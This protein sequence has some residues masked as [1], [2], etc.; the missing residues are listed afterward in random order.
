MD[1]KTLKMK[2]SKLRTP[3]QYA[4]AMDSMHAVLKKAMPH[5]TGKFK[6]LLGELGDSNSSAIFMGI[7]DS[8]NQPNPL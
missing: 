8:Q 7:R 1:S 2:K 3:E 5:N 6:G 4:K